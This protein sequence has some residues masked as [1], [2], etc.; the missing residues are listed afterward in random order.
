MLVRFT[1]ENFASFK[2]RVELAMFPGK[3]QRHESHVYKNKGTVDTLKGA[4]IY[5]ANASGKS[6][7][8]KAVR[9]AQDLIE[10]G[11][12][13]NSPIS[14]KP[15]KLDAATIKGPTRIEFELIHDGMH[16]AYGFSLNS[17][18]VIEEWLY[19]ITPRAERKI[20][21][22][23]FD[24]NTGKSVFNFSGIKFK[25]PE[26]EQFLGFIAKATRE[27]QLFLTE[28]SERKVK[29]NVQNLDAIFVALSWFRNVLTIVT[30]DSIYHGLE[31]RVRND[32]QTSSL[33]TK[34][35]NYFD[36]GISGLSVLST[37]LDQI[38]GMP[39]SIKTQLLK[40]TKTE[41]RMQAAFGGPNNQRYLFCK[42]GPGED[43][44]GVMRLVTEHKH[45]DTGETSQ[46]EVF[47]ESDGT[48]RLM[49]LIPAVLDLGKEE[50][51]FFVD[52]LDR[53]LHPLIT[54]RI[55]DDFMNRTPNSKAQLI[56]TTHEAAVLDQDILRKDEVW[57]VKKEI[58]GS[59]K[60]YS[61]EEFK[62]RFDADIRKGYLNGRFGAIPF[63]HDQHGL[64]ELAE[65]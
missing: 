49:D 12:A 20:F 57:F 27:N 16:L 10:E 26:E 21:T 32:I 31:V 45:A 2:G 6:N 18:R 34:Y 5:G 37:D 38:P 17:T 46:F 52:E 61:L 53:S 39:K 48:R 3:T 56:V 42:D 58:D 24:V 60:I 1:V 11:T 50:K 54:T 15:F 14:T 43:D 8:I 65:A 59:S 4:V 41:G 47:E 63:I 36:T 29:E 44:W 51:V 64:Q 30:P 13:A 7:V 33:Y 23:E 55:I 28:V 9:F 40:A 62:P 19:K 35:L 22:R 25:K